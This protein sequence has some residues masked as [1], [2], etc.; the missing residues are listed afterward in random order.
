M[1]NAITWGYIARHL[2]LIVVE[3][4]RCGRRG[5]YRTDKLLAQYGDTDIGQFQKDITAD[6][7]R[8]VPTTEVGKGCAPPGAH[9]AGASVQSSEIKRIL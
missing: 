9:A 4:D 2:A 8:N 7:P 3:S 1:P 6:C 5:K